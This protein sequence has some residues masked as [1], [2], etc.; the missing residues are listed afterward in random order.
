M[1]V[2]HMQ[3]L[4][5]EDLLLL[6][7]NEMLSLSWVF[8]SFNYHNFCFSKPNFKNLY[9]WLFGKDILFLFRTVNDEDLNKWYE[10]KDKYELLQESGGAAHWLTANPQILK[11]FYLALSRSVNAFSKVDKKVYMLFNATNKRTI[12]LPCWFNWSVLWVILL[13]IFVVIGWTTS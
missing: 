2:L 7:K 3:L 5:W 1:F 12:D 11:Y 6:N 13:I 4:A 10:K 8:V 9:C